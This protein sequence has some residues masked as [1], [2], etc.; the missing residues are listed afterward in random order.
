MSLNTQQLAT[1]KAYILAT[2]ALAA[3]SSGAGTDY[4]PFA[5]PLSAPATPTFTVWRTSLSRGD[6]MSDGFDF[7][8][9]DN[10]TTGQARIWDWLFID[11]PVNPSLSSRRTAITE[12]W[13]GTA[14]KVAVGVYVLGQSKRSASQVEKL[15]ASGT[16]SVADPATMS[17]EGGISLNEVASMFNV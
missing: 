12:T 5:L 16:G 11:G 8:Q 1:V 2:P 7:T 10:L 13:K 4:N 6:A 9:V 15:L 14:G 3:L 17:Y